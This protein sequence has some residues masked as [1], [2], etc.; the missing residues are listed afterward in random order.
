MTAAPAVEP[1]RSSADAWL[2]PHF[3]RVSD[4]TPRLAGVAYD[5][6]PPG[7]QGT[8][9][10]RVVSAVRAARTLDVPHSWRSSRTRATGLVR[11]GSA[12]RAGLAGLV[13]AGVA[14]GARV[15]AALGTLPVLLVL[16]ALLA[17]MG[18]APGLFGVAHAAEARKASAPIVEAPIE[19]FNRTVAVLRAGFLG[20]PPEERARRASRQLRT[21]LAADAPARWRCASRGRSR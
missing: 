16:F 8:G 6:P 12:P 14:A 10:A 18:P 13:S 21:L 1:R 5:A 19:V 17:W 4:C 3:V 11:E 20:V 7:T 9:L 15:A 2:G